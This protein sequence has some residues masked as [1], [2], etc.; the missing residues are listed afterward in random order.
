[1]KKRTTYLLMA[2]TLLFSAVFTGCS[3]NGEK[4]DSPK[5]S[6]VQEES[7]TQKAEASVASS[8]SEAASVSAE[9]DA[10]LPK[11]MAWST[12]GVGTSTYV[13]AAGI[14]D[15]LTTMFGTQIR[16]LPSDTSVG[17]IQGV[18]NGEVDY[19]LAADETYFATYGL[20]DF[21]NLEMGPYDNIRALLARPGSTTAVTTKKSGINTAADFAGKRLAW[22]PGS[23]SVNIK[24]VALLAFANLTLDDVTLVMAPSYSAAV[25]LIK[26]GDADWMIGQVT[27]SH[28][29]E[30]D[31]TDTGVKFIE[32][33]AADV[34]GWARLQKVTPWL[35]PGTA[36]EGVGFT[37][38]I[39]IP[40][41]VNPLF[42]TVAGKSADEVY[43]VVKAMDETYDL[44]KGIDPQMPDWALDRASNIP[45]Q[46][47]YHEGAIRY[48]KEKGLWTQ[49]HE[50]WNNQYLAEIETVK[51]AWTTFKEKAIADKLPEEKIHDAWIAVLED[52]LGKEFPANYDK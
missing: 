50:D 49:E 17:R 6:S 9:A 19:T 12:F 15:A 4:T 32:F 48:F 42:V 16:I 40:N 7:S 37:E 29:Y 10:A 34:E 23:T 3:G 8:Q 36:K 44:Y 18:V 35:Y 1:M 2:L 22:I 47:P 46:C 30:L 31:S 21:A 52:T 14:A 41:Y 45:V 33:P 51:E 13:Q 39:E 20:Y 25:D 26:N 11:Q 38:P 27:A 28:W 5:A 24:A 43:A